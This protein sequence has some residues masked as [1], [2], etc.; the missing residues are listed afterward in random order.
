MSKNTSEFRM[1]REAFGGLVALRSEIPQKKNM[2]EYVFI[3][4]KIQIEFIFFYPLDPKGWLL[5]PDPQCN[6]C[7]LNPP[8]PDLSTRGLSQLRAI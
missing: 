6:F 4:T 2:I 5:A 7:C 3:Y 8:R 1:S